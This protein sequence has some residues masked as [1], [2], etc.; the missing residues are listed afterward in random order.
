[1]IGSVT[2]ESKNATSG[3]TQ[4]H[5]DLFQRAKKSYGVIAQEITELLQNKMVPLRTDIQN[6]GAPYTPN[7]LPEMIKN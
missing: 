1:M 6:A 7:A 3:P 4:T 2:Y 5:Q